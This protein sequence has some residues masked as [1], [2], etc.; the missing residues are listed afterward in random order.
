MAYRELTKEDFLKDFGMTEELIP[1]FLIIEGW[2]NFNKKLEERKN[3][4]DKIMFESKE[5]FCFIGEKDG[6][7]IGY[8][9]A[10][11]P[12]LS[13]EIVHQFAIFGSKIIQIGCYGGLQKNMEIG[14]FLIAS[15]AKSLDGVSNFY[16][17]D[18]EYIKPSK[19][20]ADFVEKEIK[21]KKIPYFKEK[22]I[23]TPTMLGESA[24]IISNWSK[25]GFFGVDME[26]ASTIAIANYFNVESVSILY[27]FDLIIQEQTIMDKSRNDQKIRVLRDKQIMNIVLN[28]I[29]N[30]K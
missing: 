29:K 19:K 26:S 2:Y 5:D 1:E 17:K 13:G 20:L 21:N 25:Q 4:F 6:I 10:Y 14:D 7:K 12:T 27:L 8:C 16:Q 22:L 18:T 23:S 28:V 9:C 15:E 3:F 11:G 24:E 30:Y